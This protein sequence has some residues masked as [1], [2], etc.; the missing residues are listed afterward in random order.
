MIG[1]GRERGPGAEF[2]ELKVAVLYGLAGASNTYRS[3]LVYLKLF[4]SHPTMIDDGL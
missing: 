3:I 2:S 1:G 4:V